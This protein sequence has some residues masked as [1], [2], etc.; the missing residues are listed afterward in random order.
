VIVRTLGKCVIVR[1]LGKCVIVRTLGKCVIVRTHV[2]CFRRSSFFRSTHA[3]AL[4]MYFP[5]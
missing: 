4:E 2:I 1:T 5:I 3:C